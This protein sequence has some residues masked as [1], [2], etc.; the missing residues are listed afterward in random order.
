MDDQIVT[1]TYLAE[2]GPQNTDLTL[3]TALTR[4]EELGLGYAVVA[5]DSGRTARQ[6]LEVFGDDLEVVA[7]TNSAKLRLPI[8][9]LHDYTDR[10]RAHREELRSKGVEAIPVGMSDEAMAELEADGV[11]VSRIDWGRLNKF[12]R[13]DVNSIDCLGVAV[14]VA[15]VCAVWARMVRQVPVDVDLLALAGTGFGGGGAD[16]ALVVR[17]AE[18]WKDFR[19]LETLIRPRVSPP[20]MLN[21]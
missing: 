15:L 10:F 6:A 1:V 14:R 9:K 20:S 5:T 13:R 12:V 21:K 17:T 7:V 3:A 2:P 11:K 16:T 4:A 18:R 8:D 19:V